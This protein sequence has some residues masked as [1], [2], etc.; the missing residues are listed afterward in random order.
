MV[1]M[2]GAAVMVMLCWT[3]GWAMATE[4]DAEKRHLS[5]PSKPSSSGN[6]TGGKRAA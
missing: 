2:I 5:S 3:L 6:D 4:S 1:E